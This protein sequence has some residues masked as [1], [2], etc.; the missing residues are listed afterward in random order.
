[1]SWRPTKYLLGTNIY[2]HKRNLNLCLTNLFVTNL[3]STILRQIQ[4]ALITTKTFLYEKHFST[5]AAFPFEDL[6]RTK[7]TTI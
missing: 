4:E 5:P 1:M 7:R 2:L 3:Y 6:K